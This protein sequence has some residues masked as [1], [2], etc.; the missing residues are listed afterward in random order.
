[1]ALHTKIGAEASKD[2]GGTALKAVMLVGGLGTRLRPLT[3]D[4]K[5]ELMPVAGRPFL[6]H[7]LANLAKH[8]VDEAILTTGYL[9][10]AFETFPSHHTHGVKLTIVREEEPLDT[11][12]AVKNVEHLL[13]GTFLV[14]NGD[15]L[16]GLDI[17]SLVAYHRERETLG[18]LTLKPVEDPSAY[19]LVPVD[20]DGR[21]ERF[22]EKPKTKEEVVTDLINAGTY[23]LEP[24]ALNYVPGGEPF[25]FE[26]GVRSGG[27]VD[28]GLFPLLLAEGE[29]LYG[30]VSRDYWLDTGTPEKYIQANRDVLAGDVGLDPAGLG[31]AGRV[32][33]GRGAEVD[34][35]A[36]LAGPCAVGGGCT[37]ERGATI[38][39]YSS[40]GQRC[41]IGA[42]AVVGESVL[43]DDVIVG[44][45]TTVAGSVLGNEVR[46]GPGCTVD[47]AVVGAGVRIGAS[48]ELRRGIRL[49]PGVDVPD[50]G[51]TF[52]AE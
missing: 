2:R 52:R 31:S 8:G 32:W 23:V 24:D 26:G 30:Y 48:N 41:R 46:I 28:V 44:G 9:A 11:C 16:T 22:I 27:R 38:G 33:I 6:E 29:A 10:D 12:G 37:V 40:I 18:T 51:I 35:S 50:R 25:S 7:V 47:D 39:P 49:W 43:H 3:L 14:C 21:I 45:G 5:K 42:G 17:S 34:P 4:T 19:G 15:I 20:D 36:S 13:D 1:M